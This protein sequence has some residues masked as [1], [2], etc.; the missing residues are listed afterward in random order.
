MSSVLEIVAP[1]VTVA[2]CH[3]AAYSTWPPDCR[4][5]GT[6]LVYELSVT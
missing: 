4:P 2:P 6:L 3:A 5:I 1:S